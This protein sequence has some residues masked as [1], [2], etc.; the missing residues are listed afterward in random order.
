MFCYDYTYKN[1]ETFSKCDSR[2]MFSTYLEDAGPLGNALQD[3]GLIAVLEEDGP[4][5]VHVLHLHQHGGC[6]GPPAACWAVVYVHQQKHSCITS[7]LEVYSKVWW[8]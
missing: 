6:A 3:A 4:V 1:K 8:R 7:I 2:S 5:V